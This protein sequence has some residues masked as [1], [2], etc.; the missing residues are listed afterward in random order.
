M[1]RVKDDKCLKTIAHCG[2]LYVIRKPLGVSQTLL[3]IYFLIIAYNRLHSIILIK[4][5][6]LFPAVSSKPILCR[7]EFAVLYNINLVL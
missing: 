4:H 6:I 7:R 1:I 5:F 3:K 2:A